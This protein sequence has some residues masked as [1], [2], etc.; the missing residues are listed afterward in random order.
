M[1]H[2]GT[3]T[4]G[5]PA[6]SHA[7]FHVDPSIPLNTLLF[8]VHCLKK[9]NHGKQRK[10]N[11]LL[12]KKKASRAGYKEEVKLVCG[13]WGGELK[14]E[15]QGQ[16]WRQIATKQ[17]EGG[18]EWDEKDYWLQ[19]GE[20][21]KNRVNDL[22]LFFHRFSMETRPAVPTPL[23]LTG[24]MRTLYIHLTESTAASPSTSTPG[25]TSSASGCLLQ[26]FPPPDWPLHREGQGGKA[27]Q[28]SW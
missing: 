22:S 8:S 1:E 28:E 16:D 15:T 21:N 12:G 11:P 25:F 18:A 17:C 9:T 5:S 2:T 23:L 20:E 24:L 13:C 19:V 14:I 27:L 7:N 3:T 26:S 4:H 10:S 6:A